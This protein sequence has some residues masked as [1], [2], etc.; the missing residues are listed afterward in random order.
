LPKDGWTVPLTGFSGV[1]ASGENAYNGSKQFNYAAKHN[2]QV[3]FTD[4][5]GGNNATPSNPLSHNYA[6]LQQLKRD[7]EENE[8]ADYSWITPDQYNDMHSTLTGGYKG[9]LG[10]NANIKQGDD[11]LKK[12]IPIIMNSQAY[13]DNGAIIIWWDESES[14]AGENPDDFTHTIGE[15]VISPLARHNNGA[16][17]ASDVNYTHSSDLRTMEEIFGLRPFLQDAEDAHDLSGLF[18]EGAIPHSG[19]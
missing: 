10:D 7:L 6:P 16:P 3:F 17:Y 2:P 14:N 5:N 1:F 9:L 11:F 8:V 13:K 18:E 4:T 15:I 19:E 12:I